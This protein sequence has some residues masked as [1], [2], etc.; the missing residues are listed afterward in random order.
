MVH[1]FDSP[2]MPTNNFQTRV[3]ENILYPNQ[4]LGSFCNKYFNYV[5]KNES[6]NI[7]EEQFNYRNNLNIPQLPDFPP[8]TLFQTNNGAFKHEIISPK[9]IIRDI[10]TNDRGFVIPFN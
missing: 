7:N 1:T 5:Y 4:L 9:V 8:D 6:N 2:I 3:E 10:S